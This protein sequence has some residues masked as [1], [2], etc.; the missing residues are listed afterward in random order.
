MVATQPDPEKI[1]IPERNISHIQLA[2]AG[3]GIIANG[4]I[5]GK[6]KLFHSHVAIIIQKYSWMLKILGHVINEPFNQ[7]YKGIFR[8][9]NQQLS[10]CYYLVS[11]PLS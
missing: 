7:L 10:R 8:M 5:V 3:K 9:K 6:G 2:Y 1:D 4:C 11:M